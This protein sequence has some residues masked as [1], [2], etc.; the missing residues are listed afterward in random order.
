ML[1]LIH[2]PC[3]GNMKAAKNYIKRFEQKMAVEFNCLYKEEGGVK[4]QA[5]VRLLSELAR[6]SLD[7][8]ELRV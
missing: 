8:F 7:L 2:D 1:S 6:H 5:A 4:F 3:L